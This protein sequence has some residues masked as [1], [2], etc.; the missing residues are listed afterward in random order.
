MRR[1]E[2]LT[3]GAG[4]AGL[5]LLPSST[6]WAS[7]GDAPDAASL[8]ELL[9][10]GVRAERC[11]EVYLY[12]GM[13]SFESFYVNEDN[14]KPDDPDPTLRNT[15]WYLFKDDHK[16]V[17][18]NECGLGDPTTWLTEIGTDANGKT[19]KIGPLAQALATRPDI[20]ER[21]RVV[22]L[23]HDFE[24][25]ESAVPQAMCG[26][27]LGNPRMAGFGTHVQRYWQ[28]HDTT[29]RVVPFSFVFTPSAATA[30]FN[31][32]TAMSVGMHPGSARSLNIKASASM[33]LSELLG[34]ELVGNDAP[35]VDA[36]LERY[37]TG[38][39]NRYVDANGVALRSRANSDQQF[40]IAALQNA[41]SLATLLPSSMFVVENGMVCGV[42]K[43]DTSGMVLNASIDL[44]T[45]P[46]TPAKYVSCVDGGADFYGDLPYDVHA[47]HLS[48]STHNMTHI[49]RQLAAR[50]NEPG[51]GDVTKLDIDD[52]LIIITAEFGRTPYEQ[53][54][55]SGG[56]NHHPHGY[57]SV[58]IGGPVQQGV[59][60][61]IG[62]D[63]YGQDYV[64][65]AEFRA[66]ALAALG[67]YPFGPEGFAVGDL[68]DSGAA[69]ELDS[70]VWLHEHIL[71]RSS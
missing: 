29:G 49:F 11:L 63:G 59:S 23:R 60:G 69:D 58:L 28:D 5:G 3:R 26:L 64:T 15:Q 38:N 12:G 47:A 22:V 70:L 16:A 65:P 71:G 51:E 20:L 41:P 34:R 33:N 61:S 18:Q 10:P 31:T 36:L 35:R 19:I 13:A 44:L 56:T 37:A 42:S 9:Q 55:G 45:D 62:P 2:F 21:M 48:A 53:Y 1:R 14:G 43:Q 50:I 24:P 25:H 57:V 68:V 8:A 4:V 32:Q 46:V 7:F 6:A 67:I 39:V 52:T 40:A 30:T 27:R 17:F 66:A 54:A